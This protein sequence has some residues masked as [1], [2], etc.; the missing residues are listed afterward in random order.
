MAEND[1]RSINARSFFQTPVPRRRSAFI[2][3]PFSEPFSDRVHSA[4]RSGIESAGLEP[5]RAD[6]VYR[7]SAVLEK[8]L[9]GIGE[10]E[11]VIADLTK[12][13]ANVFYELGIGHTEK[14]NV[15][16]LAQEIDDIPVDLRPFEYILYTTNESGLDALTAD[17]ARVLAALPSEPPSRAGTQRAQGPELTPRTVR[18][19]LRETIRTC[20]REW[21]LL[22]ADG[23]PVAKTEYGDSIGQRGIESLIPRWQP[24]FLQP[25]RPVEDLG[26][27]VVDEGREELIRDLL[28]A[29]EAAHNFEIIAGLAGQ[30]VSGQPSM[31]AYRTWALWGA[32]AIDREHW[33][34][35]GPLLR[36][37]VRLDNYLERR[38]GPIP[39]H[40][41]FFYPHA[42][43]GNG[44]VAARSI[45]EQP[46]DFVEKYFLDENQ[47]QGDLGAFLFSAAVARHVL[48][49][50]FRTITAGWRHSPVQEFTHFVEQLEGDA[51]MASNF[52]LAVGCEYTGALKV[53]WADYL[54]DI[55]QQMAQA[56]PMSFDLHR[57]PG[58]FAEP[59]V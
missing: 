50:D 12:R 42:A 52:A 30:I 7:S 56:D 44:A 13:N 29:I 41:K 16:L 5:V 43:A 14:Q 6:D 17:I 38:T 28:P 22:V 59:L 32:L 48:E 18:E 55:L 35:L 54:K 53:K 2:L 23:I 3:M 21:A 25:W 46:Q 45:Y 57:L 10:A 11:V 40:T 20:R 15:V 31:I 26:L 4:I 37:P 58:D 34:V 39:T 9:R 24:D 1:A 49:P 51:A 27:Q 36:R 33:G 8:I 47:F 19:F